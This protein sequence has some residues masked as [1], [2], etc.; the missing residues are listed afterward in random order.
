MRHRI[1]GVKTPDPIAWNW[2]LE[3]RSRKMAARQRPAGP[4]RGRMAAALRAAKA[5]R[6]G[7]R[8]HGRGPPRG[9]G[10]PGRHA[11]AWPLPTARPPAR[12]SLA[13]SAWRPTRCAVPRRPRA[14]Q[15]VHDGKPRGARRGVERRQVTTAHEGDG[16]SGPTAGAPCSTRPTI[17][18][19]QPR[20]L[21]NSRRWPKTAPICAMATKSR[22]AYPTVFIAASASNPSHPTGSD[23]ARPPR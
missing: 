16:E 9:K 17:V 3:S 21:A 13:V 1:G 10:R 20:G 6:A 5:G 7:T 12:T 2:S 8:S 19:E 22:D 23:D 4:A 11:V 15:P 14:R 18:A